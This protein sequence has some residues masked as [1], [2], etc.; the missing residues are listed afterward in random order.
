ML[1][2]VTYYLLKN[3]EKLVKL[4][5]ELDRVVGDDDVRLEHLNKCEYMIG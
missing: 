5:E 4:R 2:F 1:T 3:P